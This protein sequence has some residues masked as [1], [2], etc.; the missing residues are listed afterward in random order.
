MKSSFDPKKGDWKIRWPGRVARHDLVYLSP[1]DDPM[2]GIALGNGDV[3]VLCWCESSRLI[4]VLNRCD[5]WDDAE[6][7][8]FHNW[9]PQEEELSTTLRQGGRI[10]LDF[11]MPVF[12]IFY[13][14]DFEARLGLADATMTLKAVG[15][16][17]SVA[18]EALVDHD[19]GLL[20][21]DVQMGL[22]DSPCVEV[23]LERFG[24]RTFAHWYSMIRRDP[25]LGLAGTKASVDKSGLYVSHKL[26]SGAFA[27]GVKVDC[28][29]RLRIEYHR[30]H[31]H[32]ARAV[33]G[34]ARPGRFGL[35]AVITPPSARNPVVSV[36]KT[37]A[38]GVDI[39]G[40]K[41]RHKK[42]WKKFWL[43]SY[44]DF[45]DDYL[46]NLWHLTMYYAAASQRGRY[47]GRFIG[48]LWS[49][50][51]DVQQW[52]FYFHWNQQQI[53]WPLNTAGHNDLIDSYLRF[54]S[55]GLPHARRDAKERFGSDGAFVSDVCDRRGCNS[56]SE[57]LN[58]TPVAQIAMEFWRQYKY[59][60]DMG[61]LKT[62]T[63]PYMLEAARFFESLFR[64][65]KDGRY[66]TRKGTAYE[67]WIPL[68][69]CITERASGEALFRAT[70]EACREAGVDEPATKKWQRILDNLVEF[71]MIEPDERFISAD[72]D[73]PEYRC[74]RFKGRP[75]VAGPILASGWG[76][77]EKRFLTSMIPRPS[78]H[79]ECDDLGT[80]LQKTE[81]AVKP[82]CP[83][84]VDTDNNPGIFPWSEF[85]PIYPAGLIGLGSAGGE[86]FN[87]AV[88]TVRLFSNQFMGWDVL[89]IAMARL[90]LADELGEVLRAMPE[91]WQFYC[92]GWGNYGPRDVQKIEAAV[93]HARTKVRDAEVVSDL[94]PFPC[95]PFR[96][97]GM[98]AMSVLTAAMNEA[99]LQSHDGVIRV[100]PAAE[101]NQHSRFTLHAMDGFVVSSEINKGKPAWISIRSL[102]GGIC[103]IANPWQAAY[104]SEDGK[105]TART[106]KA[107]IEFETRSGGTFTL[108]PRPG[109]MSNWEAVAE[110]PSRNRT[111]KTSPGGMMQLGLPRTF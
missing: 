17:G 74:G 71:P 53:Y 85:A 21:C 22:K 80:I 57:S 106:D 38:A 79:T 65:E 86:V 75:T 110:T 35:T 90:G 59:T 14:S 78:N 89:P 60:G 63:L 109:T 20:C 43:R 91:R 31:S 40:L 88:N 10:V 103:R 100:A 66:H 49:W 24:S 95:W 87:A 107:I 105:R 68:K 64:R 2:R 19:T 36:R 61:F 77:K 54:R 82:L 18:V 56:A 45:G 39:H 55:G 81:A 23:T 12:D 111:P 15:P 101:G 94:I 69:D 32:A 11:R 72:P 30:L 4:F 108:V 5:L 6:F 34:G 27:M 7:G 33:V 44:M 13:L 8:S 50:S 29:P 9:R 98:E 76:L 51:R 28:S 41:R 96:H 92:N 46:D 104:V 37:L 48:G 3:G 26:T 93:R 47:P 70:I 73:G 102:R 83:G 25:R 1:P 16:F 52:N 84:S 97:M 58:H 99:L 42:A 67:G 62:R